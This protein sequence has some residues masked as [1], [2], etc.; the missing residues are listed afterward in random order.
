MSNTRAG[1]DPE[2][3]RAAHSNNLEENTPQGP[4][5]IQLSSPGHT[6]GPSEPQSQSRPLAR[7]RA[8]GGPAHRTHSGTGESR[9]RSA[10]KELAGPAGAGSAR[11]PRDSS[12]PPTR[13]SRQTHTETH[14][15][16]V[17]HP[18]ARDPPRRAPPGPGRPALTSCRQQKATSVQRPLHLPMAPGAA[19]AVRRGAPLARRPPPPPP[20]RTGSASSPLRA[21]GGGAGRLGPGPGAP[22]PQGWGRPLA[23]RVHGPLA[24]AGSAAPRLLCLAGRPPGAPPAP[25]RLAGSAERGARAPSAAHSSTAQLGQPP[26]RSAAAASRPHHVAPPPPPGG[27][28]GGAG[29]GGL[30][31]RGE[32][33]RG[34]EVEGGGRAG[35]GVEECRLG[36][37]QPWVKAGLHG[38]CDLGRVTSPLWASGF[39]AKW[40]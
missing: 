16:C 30:G 27:S 17:A 29:R 40:E 23:P 18:H 37:G 6:P 14:T 22:G 11:P 25:G 24:R 3:R 1:T 9:A 4:Q 35:E 38:L 39:L 31:S 15:G 33:R 10:H 2:D 13:D 21:P 8:G 20:R 32:G 19:R 26:G 12:P 5:G 36:G 34:R 7:C 28:K